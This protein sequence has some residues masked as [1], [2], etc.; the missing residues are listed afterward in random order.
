MN[1]IGKEYV[2][3]YDRVHSV[4][5]GLGIDERRYI[6]VTEFAAQS[7]RSIHRKVGE[8]RKA[9]LQKF[10]N[11]EEI[12]RTG[13]RITRIGQIYTDPGAQRHEKAPEHGD[14]MIVFLSRF[15]NH[16]EHRGHREKQH[17]SVLS[18]YSVVDRLQ[19]DSFFQNKIKKP[20]MMAPRVTP[21]E[22]VYTYAC[23]HTW[24]RSRETAGFRHDKRRLIAL[25]HRKERKAGLQ[26]S[27]QSM[28]L[29]EFHDGLIHD[30]VE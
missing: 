7:N 30:R 29:I 15:N 27:V 28:R 20:Q 11:S 17:R 1:A 12:I 25:F 21:L 5:P 13:T 19:S 23:G 26:K 22:G 3:S 16:R 18:V 4:M 24:V 10:L 2:L 9:Q 6:P 8:E 14:S